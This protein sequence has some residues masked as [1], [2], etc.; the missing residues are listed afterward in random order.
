[1][2]GE[3][4]QVDFV[5]H[6][7]D[8]LRYCAENQKIPDNFLR[9][10]KVLLD[11]DH[12][13]DGIIPESFNAPEKRP[14]SEEMFTKLVNLF[15]FGA[16]Y[17][18]KQILRDE[19]WVAKA[20]DNE[21]KSVLL[22]MIEWHEQVIHGLDYDTWHAGRFICEWASE[23]TLAELQSIFGHFD[24]KD[25][26]EALQSTITLFS[27]LAQDIAN[28]MQYGYP[29]DLEECVNDW[30]SQNDM[31]T[32]STERLVLRRWNEEEAGFVYHHT[33]DDVS[34]PLMN[35]TRIGHTNYMTKE[36]WA[37]SQTNPCK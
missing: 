9:G 5:I 15:W 11:K 17:I 21:L 20:R 16:L 26:W 4:R 7:L 29:N 30:M 1:M 36:Q 18:A 24:Q 10:V 31:T 22:Q 19:L 14:L 13:L 27:R 35:E 12:L 33:C 2:F 6:S 28:R 34:V 23:E 3:G 8:S 37:K 32:L 25:S